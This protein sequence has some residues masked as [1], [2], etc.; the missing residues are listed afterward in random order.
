MQCLRIQRLGR[1]HAEQRAEN[2]AQILLGVGRPH[3]LGEPSQGH[4]EKFLHDLI[5]DD[6]LLRRQGLSDEFRGFP[7]LRSGA[8]NE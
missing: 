3:R 1:M 5:A 7:G 8:S 4:I 6:A 2:R